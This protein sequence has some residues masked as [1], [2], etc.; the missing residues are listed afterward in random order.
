MA[1][2]CTILTADSVDGCPL[3]KKGDKIVANLPDL[4]MEVSDKVCAF[5]LAALLHKR[6]QG[7]KNMICEK[8]ENFANKQSYLA[9]FQISEGTLCCPRI[10]E[11]TFSVKVEEREDEISLLQEFAGRADKQALITKLKK[12]PI[13]SAVKADDMFDILHELKVKKFEKGDIILEKGQAGK[14]LFVIYQ[15]AVEVIQI[16]KDVESAIGHIKAGDCF[17][18]MSLLTGEPV[19]ATIRASVPSTIIMLER[20]AFRKLMETTPQMGLMFTKLLAQ[21]IKNTNQRMSMVVASGMVGQLQTIPFPELIQTLC[22]TDCTGILHLNRQGQQ[23]KIYI[24]NGQVLDVGIDDNHGEECFYAMLKWQKGDFR[25]E[26]KE[27]QVERTIVMDVM[28]ML[29]EG[30]RRMDEETK[31]FSAVD[32]PNQ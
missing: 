31:R 19:S 13:F 16:F 8:K 10:R 5:V 24:Q 23:G 11:V 27:V 17:G 2:Y 4:D 1:I 32:F 7:E 12:I 22:A 30:M 29:L 25:F 20:P 3:Y 6:L 28:S 18:E 26:Q 15:G 21:R 14:Y 9:E